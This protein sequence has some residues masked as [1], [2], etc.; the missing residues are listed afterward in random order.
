DRVPAAE[1]VAENLSRSVARDGLGRFPDSNPA[2]TSA[3]FRP[4]GAPGPGPVRAVA[5]YEAQGGERGD[6]RRSATLR[7]RAR[8]GG[9]YGARRFLDGDNA[10][11]ERSGDRDLD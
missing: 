9:R 6:G 2:R 10:V 1:G 8:A 11:H 3:S 4:E 7:W 5:A